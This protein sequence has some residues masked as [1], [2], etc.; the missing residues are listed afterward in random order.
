MDILAEG[1]L[2]ALDAYSL[3][4]QQFAKKLSAMSWS[5][6]RAQH[7]RGRCWE[8]VKWWDL[9]RFLIALFGE[10]GFFFLAEVFKH[11]ITLTIIV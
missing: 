4:Q 1:C 11:I 10:E 6:H 9:V 2:H 8:N 3:A 7:R 5:T